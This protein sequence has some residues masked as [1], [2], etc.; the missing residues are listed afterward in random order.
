M[1]K[2]KKIFSFFTGKKKLPNAVAFVDYEHWYI[3][4]EKIYDQK[5]DIQAWFDDLKK[6]CN[7]KEVV[8]FANFS[9]FKDKETETKRIRSFTNKIIDTFNPDS[10]Y[11]KDFT[12]FIILDN[13]YQKAFEKNSPELFI[14][15]SGDGHFSSALAFLRNF[16]NKQVGIYGATGCISKN[17]INNADWYEEVPLKVDET[18]IIHNHLFTYL[19]ECE[20]DTTYF[21][22]FMRTAEEISQQ[23]GIDIEKVT[24]VMSDLIKQDYISQ[25]MERTKRARPIKVL[26]TDWRLVSRHNI[27]QQN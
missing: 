4:M 1:N 2:S 22:T 15:F 9:K 6:K 16:C 27:W 13:I 23:T 26:K 10:H 17:L 5:P 14:I 20:K 24:N 3:S 7:I 25:V 12:D 21:P 11:K 18:A 8:F 19:K